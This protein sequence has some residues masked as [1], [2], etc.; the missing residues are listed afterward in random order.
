MRIKKLQ[1]SPDVLDE[2]AI[3]TD[4]NL[5]CI[6]G[7]NSFEILDTVRLLLGESMPKKAIDGLAVYANVEI[8]RKDFSVCCIFCEGYVKTA[9][10]FVPY[11]TSFSLDDTKDYVIKTKARNK[12][13]GN[14]LDAHT[15]LNND[16]YLSESDSLMH[17]IDEFVL[18]NRQSDDDRPLFIYGIFER[19]D[20]AADVS[21]LL[22]KLNS[23]NR[24]IFIAAED[25]ELPKKLIYPFVCTIYAST[26][27]KAPWQQLNVG[28]TYDG[29]Y[30][31]IRCPVCG[32]KTL[33]NYWICPHCA[34]EYDT[35][36]ENE[37]SSCNQTTLNKYREQYGKDKNEGRNLFT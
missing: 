36:S 34:W 17:L 10:N 35:H 16:L 29:F 1:I 14:V 22:H 13:G 4:K 5:C 20:N 27:S 32:N 25:A 6:V 11:T 12:D 8:D 2:H 33:D 15:T 23:L 21:S 9:V 37:Y 28:D 19:L 24:Q 3:P 30:T 18:K 26:S 7:R 31:V